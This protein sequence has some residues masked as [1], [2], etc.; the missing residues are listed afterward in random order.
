MTKAQLLTDLATNYN[1]LDVGTP[2]EKAAI[3][4]IKTYIVTVIAS[5]LSELNKKPVA[6]PKDIVFY[7]DDEGGGSEA[8]YYGT[9][10][11]KNT[12]NTDVTASSTT[13]DSYNRIFES[14]EIRKRTMGFILK[15]IVSVI[16]EDPGTTNHSMRLKYAYDCLQEPSDYLD[17]YMVQMANNS[18]VR[19]NGNAVIDSDLEWVVNSVLDTI[20]T[21]FGFTN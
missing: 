10:E 16:N 13:A 14:V 20:A 1:F 4:D 17:A 2:V 5:G 12:I 8:A 6:S 18:T 11:P 19:L 3:G 21:A 9:E 15:A 7:V